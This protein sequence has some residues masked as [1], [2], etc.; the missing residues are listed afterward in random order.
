MSNFTHKVIGIGFLAAFLLMQGLLAHA[1]PD[2][3]AYDIK[4]SGLPG[5]YSLGRIC[6][7]RSGDLW[8]VGADG[9]QH[10]SSDGTV[11][12]AE[13][14]DEE[15]NGVFCANENSGWVVGSRGSVLHTEDG[16]LNW[17]RQTSNVTESL[18]AITCA[19]ESSCWAVGEKGVVLTTKDG[20]N[21]WK[22]VRSGLSTSLFAVDF[23]NHQMGW[24]AGED[25]FIVRTTNG[26]KSW[27]QQQADIILF[28]DGPYA[29]RTDLL[30]LKFIDENRGWVAGAGG[31]ARTDDGGKTWEAKA[32]EDNAFIGLVSNDGKTL[33]AVSGRGTNYVTTDGGLT[34]AP[35]SQE[36]AVASGKLR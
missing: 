35:A 33:W 36:K 13:I 15:L 12:K 32:V 22:K 27:E 9:I 5:P 16:G 19:D 29:K 21:H 4:L 7:L 14:P 30:A 26:G 25:G 24:A 8:I 31:I 1:T 11:R 28:P 23:V 3:P 10:I 17:T 2:D 34:W 20:G 6:K 18:N